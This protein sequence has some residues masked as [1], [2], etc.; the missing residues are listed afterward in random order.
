VTGDIESVLT[1]FPWVVAA[2]AGAA[3]ATLLFL[4]T[5][6]G[7]STRKGIQCFARSAG[8]L[9]RA[10][11]PVVVPVAGIAAY[12]TTFAAWWSGTYLEHQAVWV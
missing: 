6:L 4:R 8:S 2:G 10:V 11:L 3:V 12:A 7:E 5:G 9:G 1:A